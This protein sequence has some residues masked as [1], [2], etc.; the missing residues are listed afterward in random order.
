M[1]STEYYHI[2]T[3]LHSLAASLP[4]IEAHVISPLSLW[5]E[6]YIQKVCIHFKQIQTQK[7][8]KQNYISYMT[9]NKTQTI[10]C[11]VQLYITFNVRRTLTAVTANKEPINVHN[12]T[13]MTRKRMQSSNKYCVFC[14][15]MWPMSVW[16]MNWFRPRPT[17]ARFPTMTRWHTW[18]PTCSLKRILSSMCFLFSNQLRSWTITSPRKGQRRWTSYSPFIR[19]TYMETCDCLPCWSP[20][21]SMRKQ[22]L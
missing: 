16:A 12:V 20:F 10:R 9:K 5:I 17:L 15:G 2:A 6:T 22:S 3:C 8:Y 14:A 7:H 4:I 1:Q 13:F 11:Y 21:A 18:S 19:E